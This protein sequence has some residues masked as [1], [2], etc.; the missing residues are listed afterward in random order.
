VEGATKGI[1]VKGG[2]ESVGTADV[3]MTFAPQ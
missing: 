3:D 2:T 1:V